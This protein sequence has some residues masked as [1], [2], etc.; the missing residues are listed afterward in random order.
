MKKLSKIVR[1]C[2]A[3][4]YRGFQF[5]C[6]VVMGLL[7]VLVV[8]AGLI[9]ATGGF[10]HRAVGL[11]PKWM[12][13]TSNV[14]QIGLALLNYEQAHRTF[15]PAYSA[16]KDGKPLLSW[17][18]L[19][20]PYLEEAALYKEFRLD[21]PWYSEHNKTFIGRMPEVY[22]GPFCK[23]PRVGMTNYLTVRGEKTMF[24]GSKGI[25]F[26]DITDG[27]SNTIMTV[28]VGDDRA[29]IW[30]KPEDLQYD[31]QN[32]LEGLSKG[33]EYGIQDYFIAGMADGSTR[34]LSA[35]MNPKK[36]NALFTRNGGEHVD[37]DSPDKDPGRSP[38]P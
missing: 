10:M 32:P 28:E 37:I 7:V 15:P 11:T 38:S 17:R 34:Q 33:K 18:M 6:Y 26:H 24:P 31:E 2:V 22:K 21:E 13:S 19:I 4:L 1:G 12:K 5:A 30:T 29:I 9:M 3:G 36:L 14:K 25:S 27:C 23:L 16:D 8:L 35:S 20:L